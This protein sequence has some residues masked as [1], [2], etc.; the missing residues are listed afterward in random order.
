MNCVN[1]KRPEDARPGEEIKEEHDM[2][3]AGGFEWKY[4]GADRIAVRSYVY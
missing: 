4:A 2:W 1:V 3:M